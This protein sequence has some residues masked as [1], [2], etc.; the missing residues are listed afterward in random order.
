MAS[1]NG[2]RLPAMASGAVPSR[3]RADACRTVVARIAAGPGRGEPGGHGSPAAGGSDP[4]RRSTGETD[5]I[6]RCDRRGGHTRR[7]GGG[8]QFE[9]HISQFRRTREARGL[10]DGRIGTVPGD[11]DERG[12][13]GSSTR[14]TRSTRR[15]RSSW[16]GS[17]G[18][19]GSPTGRTR[20]PAARAARTSPSWATRTPRASP[21]RARWPTSP[22]TC[23]AWSYGSGIIPG[24]LA[25]DTVNGQT[26]A[27]PWFGGVRGIWYRK[28]EFAKA[29]ITSPPA[30]WAELVSDAKKLQTAY[31]GTDGLG[32]P[33]DYTNAIVSFIWGAGGQVA[34]EKGGKWTAEL[35][36][37]Q[38]EA[39]IKFYADLLPDPARLAVQVRRRDRAGRPRR[40]LGWLE[41][42]LRAR[43]AGHVHRRPVGASRS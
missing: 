43:Q 16:T 30:T 4:G 8:M 39:G 38:S 25:N 33:S 13:H 17:R 21:P 26:Y 11:L 15:P 41:R 29:G 23:K 42:G 1:L 2:L 28:D 18:A 35:T 32:A 36:S 3:G 7:S 6:G 14:S 31:P 9:Q 40:D 20:C 24:N 5:Q 37:P 12:R 10:A 22:A 19:T 34:T 27:V